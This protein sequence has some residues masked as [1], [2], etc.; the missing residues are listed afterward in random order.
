MNFNLTVV[1]G[2]TVGGALAGLILWALQAY[3]FHA[4]VPGAVETAV[5]IIV[6]GACTGVASWFARER[7]K[8][9][10]AAQ[11][12]ASGAHP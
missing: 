6:P 1:Q 8:S 4:S 5:T 7:T 9:A 11:P 10:T 2:S 12:P 3:V